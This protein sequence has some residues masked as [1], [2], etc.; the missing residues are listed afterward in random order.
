ME[1][2]ADPAGWCVCVLGGGSLRRPKGVSGRPNP[3]GEAGLALALGIPIS[4]ALLP[5]QPQVGV[6]D[7][8]G[9]FIHFH[10]PREQT[11]LV[12]TTP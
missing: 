8:G 3:W 4:Q 6:G 2:E 11:R 10:L 5:F 1:K 9:V 12:L 7:G